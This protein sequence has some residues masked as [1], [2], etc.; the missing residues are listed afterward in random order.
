MN[1]LILGPFPRNQRI[2]DFLISQGYSNIK[3]TID[4]VSI[5]FL[6]AHQIDFIASNGYAPIIKPDVTNEYKHKIINIHNSYL[7][8]GRGIYGNFWSFFEGTPKGVSLSFVDEG[9]DTGDII[10]RQEITLSNQETLRTSWQILQDAVEKLFCDT[11]QDIADGKISPT[12]QRTIKELGS[13][14]NRMVSER[15]ISL[16]KE[17]WDTPLYIIEEMGRD[18][19][20]S[21]SDFWKKYGSDKY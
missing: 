17:K 21:E 6:R 14:H 18:F 9:I 13:Y 3:D 12:P 7:P 20:A 8:Y 19:R 2:Y 10:T 5:D 4:P 16:L 15:F 1:I 11:W